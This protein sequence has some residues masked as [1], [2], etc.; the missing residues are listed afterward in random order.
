MVNFSTRADDT[1]R[2]AYA[3]GLRLGTLAIFN[4]RIDRQSS[5]ISKMAWAWF[6]NRYPRYPVA[7]FQHNRVKTADPFSRCVGITTLHPIW[8]TRRNHLTQSLQRDICLLKLPPSC[9]PSRLP[10]LMPWNNSATNYPHS[11]LC[12]VWPRIT[13]AGFQIP[14][15]I[16]GLNIRTKGYPRSNKIACWN[17]RSHHRLPI[18]GLNQLA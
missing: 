4:S 10:I 15:R 14:V 1:A 2:S 18:N 13:R 5:M 6:R 16:L 8:S 11:S 12:T 3:K 9:F 17:M 7:C